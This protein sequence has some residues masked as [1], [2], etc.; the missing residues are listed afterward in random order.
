MSNGKPF[1]NFKKVAAQDAVPWDPIM[2]LSATVPLG[3]A[4]KSPDAGI[5]ELVSNF[6]MNYMEGLS[7]IVFYIAVAVFLGLL[8]QIAHNLVLL[9]AFT[10]MF[11]AVGMA[12]N[13]SPELIAMIAS[14]MLTAALGTPAGSTRS[15]MLFGNSEYIALGD[16]YKLGWFSLL[17]HLIACCAIGIPLGMLM[18]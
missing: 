14:I 8:T 2:L 12:L 10:P 5:M 1:F 16:C 3:N 13:M 4:L 7:P 18:F 11:C 6:A 15:G 9:A 17:A